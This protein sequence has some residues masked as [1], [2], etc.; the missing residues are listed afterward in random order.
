MYGTF[1]GR[2]RISNIAKYYAR[3]NYRKEIHREETKLMV[4]EPERMVWF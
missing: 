4:E 3:K 2:G 1:H